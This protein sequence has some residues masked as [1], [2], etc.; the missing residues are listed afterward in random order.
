MKGT[1]SVSGAEHLIPAQYTVIELLG[2][3]A[4][5]A[6]YLVA[7]EHANQKRFALKKVMGAV[8]EEHRGFPYEHAA[9][10]RLS[11]P[12][13]PRIY[14]VLQSDDHERFYILMDYVEGSSLEVVR[15]VMP[16]KRFSLHAA[17]TLL[18]PVME[19]VSYLHRQHPPLIHGDIRPSNIIV[20]IAGAP[21]PAK[22]VDFGGTSN[23]SSDAGQR[24][25]NFRAP[26]QFGRSA[27]RR[28]DVYALGAIFYTLL[29]GTVPPAASERLA[30]LNAGEPDPLVPMDQ[31]TPSDQILAGAIH[32]ALSIRRNDR[33]DSVE[34]FRAA[35]WQVIHAD[36]LPP[37]THLPEPEVVVPAEKPHAVSDDSLPEVETP[38]PDDDATIQLAPSKPRLV[39]APPEAEIPAPDDDATMQAAPSGPLLAP[40]PP[41]KGKPPGQPSSQGGSAVLRRKKRRVKTHGRHKRRA[42]L[43][44]GLVFLL[45]CATGAGIANQAYAAQYQKEVAL[46]QAGIQHLQTA[47]SLLQAWS[48]N[49][50]AA[51]SVTPARREFAAASAAFAQLDTDLRSFPGVGTSIPG[52]G[53]RLSAAL[54]VVPVAM[55]I[56]QAGVIGCDALNVIISGFREPL[57]TGNGLTLDNL[58]AIVDDLH[59]VEADFKQAS[60]QVNALQPGDLQLDPR[61]GKAVAA[62]HQYLPSLQALLQK[63]DQLLPALR[64]LLGIGTPA[65]YL[66]EILD[67]TQLRPGGGFIKDYGYA[68]LIGGRLS[69]AHISDTNLLDTGFTASG[70]TLALP[71]AYSWFT[72]APG[73]WSLRDSNLDADFPTAAAFAEQNFSREGSRVVLQGVMAV[74]TTFMAHMLDITGPIAIPEL[75]EKV[76]GTNLLDRI[77]Y[78]E[79]GPGERQ[80]GSVLLSPGGNA[81]RYFTEQLAQGFLARMHQ[82]RSSVLPKVLQ[83]LGSALRTKDLQIYFNDRAAE[84]LLRQAQLAASIRTSTGDNLLVVDANLAADNANQ[85]ITSA[86]DDRVTIDVSGNATHH[87][88][89]RYAWVTNNGA[90]YGPPLYRDYVRVY[91]PPGSSLQAEQG[92]QS[93][94]TSQAFG[95]EVWAGF[96]TLSYG[97]TATVTLTW[98]EKGIAKEDAAGWHYRYL[99]QRQ[100]GATWTLGVQVTLPACAVR[101]RT[102]GGHLAQNGQS[103]TL[104]QSL[105]E[106]THLAIDYRC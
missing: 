37:V 89:M 97:Q 54:H 23:V 103:V 101:A 76:T 35:L 8:R 15:Q 38:A 84:D 7:D 39:P 94:G 49:P 73:S 92:W 64:A 43:L 42:L 81:S 95:R 75:H 74:T 63:A 88:T 25:L 83:S 24:T 51:T 19:A 47:V 53:T 36:P 11:H 31:F 78:Y 41:G 80:G 96:F 61:V 9:L 55:S 52:I 100:A 71:P 10:Q 68:T 82:L 45:V 59:Q 87:T 32:R 90:A 69:A 72:L 91:V 26:E 1:Q 17:L 104:A 14:R 28:T 30:R 2:Q 57:S 21:I 60:A 79:L 86:L 70:Q 4:S 34:Q 29:T 20:P 77:H 22:L 65:Y 56:A 12:A 85:F 6:V 13:L 98:T 44:A 16:G 33:F 3:G 58:A 27:S 46:A 50:F 48:K 66:V 62:F 18:T 5:G 102:S 106:D 40:A 67:S 99:V 93:H 105:T